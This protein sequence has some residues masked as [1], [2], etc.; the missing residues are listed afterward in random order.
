MI[1]AVPSA[2]PGF[3]AP[4][5]GGH[6]R[7]RR[8]ADELTVRGIFLEHS[9]FVLR[10]VRRFGVRPGDVEDVAQDVFMVVHKK[11]PTFERERSMKAWLTGIVR[12]VTA[13]YRKRAHV[14]REHPSERPPEPGVMAPQEEA[15][16]RRRLRAILDLALDALD[17]DKRVVFVLY[18]L[19]GM[20]MA[21]V[22]ESLDC[23]LQT[24]YSRL[25]A[26]RRSVRAFVERALAEGSAR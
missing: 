25:N 20:T 8:V 5:V 9:D 10:M 1:F 24:G 13:D 2:P 7:A 17:E 14:R 3:V 4:V 12:R 6:A 11:L 22:T 21:E 18:E 15:L 26:A 16:E 19:E 23:P